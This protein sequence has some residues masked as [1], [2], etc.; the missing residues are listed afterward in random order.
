MTLV[1]KKDRRKQLKHTPG[2][3]DFRQTLNLSSTGSSPSLSLGKPPA[4]RRHSQVVERPPPTK[5]KQNK[6]PS[7][8]AETRT[9]SA[10]HRGPLGRRKRP[11]GPPSTLP[12]A[13]PGGG[14][15]LTGEPIEEDSDSVDWDALDASEEPSEEVSKPVR[16]QRSKSATAGA[17]TTGGAYLMEELV[18]EDC[19]DSDS[20]DWDALDHSEVEEEEEESLSEAPVKVR[21]SA[22]HN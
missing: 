6:P 4:S 11:I 8:D 20:V 10:S 5:Q 9:R 2:V 18:E 16:H 1:E 22:N 13:P 7:S 21:L 17:A 12:S 14:A 15:Y 3:L 19:E